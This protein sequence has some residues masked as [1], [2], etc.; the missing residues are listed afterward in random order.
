LK[1]TVSTPMKGREITDLL[2]GYHENGASYAFLGKSGL[3]YSF[4][5]TG[6]DGEQAVRIVKQLIGA[7]EYG[8]VLYY[9]VSVSG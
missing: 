9:N 3:N 7:T 1:I 2:I 4:E 6:L 5:V 8:K